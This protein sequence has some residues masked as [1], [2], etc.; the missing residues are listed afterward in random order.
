MPEGDAVLRTA[1]RLHD[2]L[3]GDVITDWELRWPGAPTASARGRT[4]VE[5]R[6][7]GKHLLHRL[8]DGTTLHTHLRMDGRW[9]VRRPDQ[10]RAADL[11]TPTLRALVGTTAAT[12]FG[13]ELGELDVIATRDEHLLVGHLG[14]DLLG[15]DWDAARAAANIAA[16][17]ARPIG[18]ALLDQR[19]LAG[20]GTIWLAETLFAER[21]HPWTPAGEL[22]DQVT[23]VVERAHTLLSATM[24]YPTSVSTGI[25]RDGERVHAFERTAL[26]CHR[27]GGAI[28]VSRIGE[29]PQDRVMYYCPTCQG[30]L[31]PA[32][33]GRPQRRPAPRGRRPQRDRRTR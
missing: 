25:D 11:R 12:A 2:A 30:G 18:A 3:A 6:S 19:N 22:G 14:P 5:V 16:R 21:V 20:I 28:R 13:L 7:R 32:D 24:R 31:G 15:P 1:R 33:D 10:V 23:A 8:D 4:T 26:P 29:P 17:P 27:C 9:R